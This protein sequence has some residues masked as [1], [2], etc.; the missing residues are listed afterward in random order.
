MKIRA[1]FGCLAVLTLLA[2][3]PAQAFGECPCRAT[4][5]METFLTIDSHVDIP[6]GYATD[7]IDPGVRT[8]SLKVDLVK[9]AEGGLDCVF[10]VSYVG[11][12]PLNA[13]G[14]TQA[15]KS[16]LEG[17]EAIRRFSTQMYPEQVSLA[18]S[19]LE[20]VNTVVSGNRCVV[21]GLENAYPLG[22]DLGNLRRFYDLGVR[23]VTLSHVG[24]NQICDSA[25]EKWELSEAEQG[26]TLDKTGIKVMRF[27]AYAQTIY[28]TEPAPPRWNGLSPLGEQVVREMNDLGMMIDLSHV[29]DST[30]FDVLRL[31]RAPVIV[32]HSTCRALCGLARSVSDEQILALRENGGVLQIN[33][34]AAYVKFPKA[35]REEMNELLESLGGSNARSRLFHLLK[36]D[37]AAY[38][39][40]TVSAAAA[41]DSIL[42][43][44][45]RP[46]V[47]DFVDHIDYV[48]S[49]AGEDYVGIGTD[50]DGGGGIEGLD[51]A[52]DYVNVTEEMIRRGYTVQQM[53]KIWGDNLLRVWGQV[54]KSSATAGSVK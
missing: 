11:Q 12:G 10:L 8:K 16:A 30:F 38:D 47:A 41:I 25:N 13:E 52:S 24:H 6:A 2:A 1:L 42:Q 48:M 14:Y 37:R 46:T 43:R 22:E 4:E 28:S 33:A 35:Q 54:E 45:P 50:F 21:L 39:S 44:Y 51:S 26:V 20:V 18:I 5:L 34:L 15:K 53:G 31:S 17:I 3:F 36:S 40:L 49:L 32:S 19:P 23:Y 9:M 27:L 7:S 29:S